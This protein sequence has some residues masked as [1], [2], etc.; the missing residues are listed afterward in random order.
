M[1]LEVISDPIVFSVQQCEN[2]GKLGKL[3][4]LP[5]RQIPEIRYFDCVPFTNYTTFWCDTMVCVDSK[6]KQHH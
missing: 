6:K 3:W 4:W 2:H 1:G 5:T